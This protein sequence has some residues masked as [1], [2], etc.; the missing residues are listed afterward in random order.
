MPTP[1][2]LVVEVP[3]DAPRIVLA[4]A[5]LCAGCAGSETGIGSDG[6]NLEGPVGEPVAAISPTE[7]VW[8]AAP[9]GYSVTADLSI[10]NSGD[11]N[12]EVYEISLL[13]DSSDSFVFD[14]VADVTLEPDAS[15]T[16]SVT[17][18]LEEAITAEASLRIRTNDDT[19]VEVI[20]PLTCV[21][22]D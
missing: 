1:V 19:Q 12:L 2:I 17:C 18:D 6:N 16:W 9:V 21:A 4:G 11:G 22:A 14:N 3:L 5:V 20:V 7:I 10:A 8:D 15:Q 13:S